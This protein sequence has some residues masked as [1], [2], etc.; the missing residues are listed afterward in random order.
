MAPELARIFALFRPSRKTYARRGRL[1][2]PR[3]ARTG[4]EGYWEMGAGSA[5]LAEA[6]ARG[7]GASWKGLA[8]L[9]TLNPV[10]I[11]RP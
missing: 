10:K 5:R 3:A 4:A 9:R 7:D 6:G 1:P 2:A 11:C 8:E